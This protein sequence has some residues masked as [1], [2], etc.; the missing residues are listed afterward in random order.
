MK[1]QKSKRQ[2]RS[3]AL[4]PLPEGVTAEDIGRALVRQIKP[5]EPVE[6]VT[7]ESDR[8]PKKEDE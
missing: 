8:R 7:D 4:P 2:K 6:P 1:N 3:V 5:V